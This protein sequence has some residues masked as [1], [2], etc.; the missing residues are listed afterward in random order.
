MKEA[1]SGNSWCKISGRLA[2]DS[3]ND[4]RVNEL[5]HSA[6]SCWATALPPYVVAGAA[7][8]RA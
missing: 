2:A 8:V 1:F 6:L 4:L 3:G 5:V 7:H